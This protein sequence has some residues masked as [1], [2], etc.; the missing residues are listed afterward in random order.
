MKWR[1][2]ALTLEKN[3]PKVAHLDK[4]HR[5]TH[6]EDAHAKALFDYC[7]NAFPVGPDVDFYNMPTY[8]LL[9]LTK[10]GR[11]SELTCATSVKP[12]RVMSV[13]SFCAHHSR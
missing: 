4:T 12:A 10:G 1:W 11:L 3:D 7:R 8:Q 5:A 2:P 9:C 13:C 6:Y